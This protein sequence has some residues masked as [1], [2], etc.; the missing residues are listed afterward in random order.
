MW[1]VLGCDSAQGG[2][3]FHSNQKPR[4]KRID[5]SGSHHFLSRFNPTQLNAMLAE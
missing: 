2:E 3:H 1:A 5:G 4:P